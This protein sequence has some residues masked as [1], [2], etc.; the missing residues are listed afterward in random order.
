ME[1]ILYY[2]E[3]E[4]NVLDK[5]L[6]EIKS[7]SIN[8]KRD[9]NIINPDIIISNDIE[10]V[11]YAY[12]PNVERY[13]FINDVKKLNSKHTELTLETDVLMTYKEDILNSYGH[14]TKST[15]LDYSNVSYNTDMRTK[16][17]SYTNDVDIEKEP[18]M[19][20]TTIGG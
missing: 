8:L 11:N 19:L 3:S 9:D 12:L 15:T 13:Y 17:M 7:I 18:T 5:I 6:E 10:N 2:T 4:N 16:I 14:F 20:L 1:L